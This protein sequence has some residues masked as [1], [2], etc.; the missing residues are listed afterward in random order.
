MTL[1]KK[2]F[3]LDLDKEEYRDNYIGCDNEFWQ[4]EAQQSLIAKLKQ[5]LDA[6]VRYGKDRKDEDYKKTNLSHNS[7]LVSAERGAGKTVFLRNCELIWVKDGGE[8]RGELHFLRV[9]DPTMLINEDNFSNVIVAQIYREV[10]DRISKNKTDSNKKTAFY[11]SLKTLADSLGKKDDF[12]GHSGVDKILR[13]N[14]GIQIEQSFHQYVETAIE[15]LNCKALVLPIDDVDMALGRAFEVI[16]D[17]RRLLGCPY[18]IPIV[19]GDMKLYTQMTN[20][21][22]DDHAY[23]KF[24]SFQLKS[25]GKVIAKDITESYLTKVFPNQMRLP[26][27]PIN[28]ITPWLKIKEKGCSDLLISEYNQLIFNNFYFLC[29]N[30]NAQKDWPTPIS[31]RELTQLARAIPPSFLK[32]Q[33][34]KHELWNRFNTWAEQKKNG[35]ALTNSDS[36]LTF[37]NR[38]MDKSFNIQTL[39]AFNPQIQ[40][41]DRYFWAEKYFYSTQSDAIKKLGEV[42]NRDILN[43]V[44]DEKVRLL[45]SMPPFEF[46]NQSFTI[47]KKEVN[48]R[49]ENAEIQQ[50]KVKNGNTIDFSNEQLLLDLYTHRDYYSTLQNRTFNVFFSQVFEIIL[51][52]FIAEKDVQWDKN[53][54][55]ILGRIPFYSLFNI[56]KTK[57]IKEDNG[58]SDGDDDGE[59]VDYYR[60]SSSSLYLAEKIQQWRKTHSDFFTTIDSNQLI[61]IFSVMFNKIFTQLNLIKS[62]V[63]DHKDNKFSRE[64]LTD[65]ARRFELVV[66][67]SALTTVIAEGAVNANTALTNK[68]A[69]LRDY[70]KFEKYD[71]TVTRNETTLENMSDSESEKYFIKCLKQHPI[72]ALHSNVNEE[73]EL[74]SARRLFILGN[75]P[76]TDTSEYARDVIRKR[77]VQ[78]WGAINLLVKKVI[79]DKAIPEDVESWIKVNAIDS[80]MLRESFKEKG[81]LN[82]DL[83]TRGKDTPQRKLVRLLKELK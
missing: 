67:N 72:F 80:S 6:A 37:N 1:D 19:S 77:S 39:M 59:E 41:D 71:Q 9:V 10:E 54:Q 61:S 45:R 49:L 47:T 52:S 31:A 73:G 21:Y 35:I 7:L 32:I 51:F 55:S 13:Y 68:H 14:S 81:Y 20:V 74:V 30:E 29:N 42:N 78:E 15:I 33:E 82:V 44:Y 50:L 62:L 58:G 24:S 76:T 34:N 66:V 65:M 60:Y 11:S 79:V 38:D 8:K 12:N 18:I 3:L 26:L 83:P 75:A 5:N 2:I 46:Y 36:Y 48:K 17:I 70:K 43:S 53:I 64:N 23:N 40:I 22:F 28:R 4:E 57:L 56:N 69:T 63:K 25:E 27:L 16:D